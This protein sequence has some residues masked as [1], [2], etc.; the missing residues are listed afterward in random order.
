MLFDAVRLWSVDWEPG[1]WEMKV[2]IGLAQ[3]KDIAPWMMLADEVTP[4]FG[5]MPDFGAVLSRKIAQKQAYCAWTSPARSL[6][7][8]IFIGGEG[9]THRIRWLA[10]S[11]EHRR[12]GIGRMLVEMAIAAIPSD[13]FIYVDTFA[14]GTPGAV[15]A[16]RL[17]RKCGFAPTE[18]WREG[19]LVRQRYM[20]RPLHPVELA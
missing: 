14:K 8:G 3:H 4:L 20:R 9:G 5:P 1:A 2:R 13:S 19:S 17:Y 16:D 18:V 15:A 6:A 12:S 7:G 10:V 11:S